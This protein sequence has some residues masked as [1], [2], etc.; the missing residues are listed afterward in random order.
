M[1][2]K[3]LVGIL[4][5]L[6]SIVFS[7]STGKI[8]GVVTDTETG[9]PLL[10]ANVQ[11]TQTLLGAVTDVNGRFLIRQV[12]PGAY[13]V[14]VSYIGYHSEQTRIRVQRD[15]TSQI[16]IA[17]R[18]SPIPFDQV[19]ATGA[20]QQE[21]LQR[22]ANSVGV[23]ASSEIRHRNR[24]RIDESLQSLA[25]VTLVGENVNVRGGSGYALLG[26][27]ASRV[28]MLIDD[29][30]VLTS[31]LGRANW[32]ILPVTEVEHIEVL[33]GAASVL[34]GAG[35]ISGVVNVLTRRPTATPSFSFRQSIGVYDD[36]SVA[37]WKWTNRTLYYYRTDASYS[38][39]FRRLGLRLAV[40][41]H[42]STGDRDNGDFRRWYFTGKA[43]HTFPDAS[44]LA[45][46]VT[47][48]RDA[49]GL[50]FKVQNLDSPLIS[51]LF[52]RINVNGT[53]ASLIYNKL[54][55][56]KFSAKIRL[57]YNAQLIGL[58]SELV[59]D[60]KPALGL[61]AEAQ[62]NWLPHPDHG[63]LFGVDYKRDDIESK[64]YGTRQ[65]NAFSPYFQEIWK[66]SSIWQIHAG[67]RYDTYILVGDSAETQLSPKVGASYNF[68][69]SSIL[70]FSVGRGF[71]VPSLAERF[72]EFESKNGISLKSNPYLQPERST[73]FDAGIRQRVG[74]N[75]SAE[76][77]AFWNRYDDLIELDQRLVTVLRFLNYPR[78]RIRG[79]ETEI[80]GRWWANRLGLE[81]AL[82]W[83]EAI[84]LSDDPAS[85]LRK[86]QALPYRPKFTA[87]VSPSFSLGPITLEADYRYVSRY[88]KTLEFPQ[89]VPQKVWDARLHYRRN[90]L[91]LQL[92]VKNAVN[93]NY[94]SVERILGEIRNFYFSI[95]GEF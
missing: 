10:G 15:S 12:P 4:L 32:D 82:T 21:D 44:N 2:Q 51:D 73:L 86:N 14:R 80:K 58:P 46:F 91:G 65:G 25:G 1:K 68:L 49:R 19:I 84:S 24:F 74:E 89:E 78:V 76:V 71:R 29:V 16:Q 36:P 90:Q 54:F 60:F 5:S 38:Q 17:L 43:V 63:L 47:Y 79:I 41:R 48:N 23:I 39:A 50:F 11:V 57:S 13:F 20:R 75:L 92:G 69:P 33:K 59:K 77:T 70:H 93:Y 37:Q 72:T 52:D 27:G 6:A 94:A 87:F 9:A 30:P 55:S 62:A 34:Y 67:L 81:A 7:Q 35:G 83:M 3:F 64:Y 95:H 22:A 88:D 85:G 8:A 40:S 28:L 31:D 66:I 42:E 45:L 18:S 56:P 26:L 53:A 61:S